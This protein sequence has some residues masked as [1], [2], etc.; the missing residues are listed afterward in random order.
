MLITAGTGDHFNAMTA[1]WGGMG[2]L[3][4]KNVCFCFVRPQRYTFE[5]MEKYDQFTLSFFD[6]NHKNK[7]MYCGTTSGRDINKIK[8]SGLTPLT[9]PESS[10]YYQEAN[11]VMACRKIYFQDIQETGFLTNL[12]QHV[13]PSKDYHRMYIGEVLY[14]L[15]SQTCSA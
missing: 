6:E 12:V 2:V 8:K 14:C 11:L 10:V 1:S 7:L 4:N 9:T 5:F 15:I 13:Y 3:W